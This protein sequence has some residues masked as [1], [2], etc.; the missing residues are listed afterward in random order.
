VLDDAL[1]TSTR[2]CDEVLKVEA[3]RCLAWHFLDQGE[4]EEALQ[5]LRHAAALTEALPFPG[6][7][8]GYVLYDIGVVQ[9][10]NGDSANARQS[11]ASAKTIFDDAG[12]RHWA[13]LTSVR[14]AELS[15]GHDDAQAADLLK[16][17]YDVFV[18]LGDR[19]WQSVTRRNQAALAARHGRRGE[20]D[21]LFAEAEHL[22]MVLNDERTLATIWTA[23][24]ESLLAYGAG[25][26]AADLEAAAKLLG[27]N[28]PHSWRIRAEA[29]LAKLRQG[30]A[31]LGL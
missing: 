11:L 12:D 9:I 20:A 21:Q 1:D 15:A 14:L 23:R 25:D 8:T 13:A 28:G 19:L 3:L 17:A 16:V 5:R 31:T 26:P 30:D 27:T 10:D 4:V 2:L 24:G 22:A 7:L 6:R 18:D 29:G